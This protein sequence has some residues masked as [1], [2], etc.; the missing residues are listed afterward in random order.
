MK[1]EEAIEYITSLQAYGIVP[2]LDNIKEL[3][4]RLGNPQKDL[5]FIHITGTNGKGSVS[6]YI[7]TVLKTA[8]YK[9]GRYSS[10]TLFEY[11][12]RIKIGERNITKKSL[13]EYTERIKK[14]CDEIVKD[15]LPHPTPF[16]FETAMAFAYFKEMQCD[17]VVLETGMGG[18]LDAT[19]V[20][21][22]VLA[23]VFTPISMDHMKFLGN[24]LEEIAKNKA[25]IIKPNCEVVTI[26]QKEEVMKV[27]NSFAEE[28]KCAV[29]IADPLQAKKQKSN[30]KG[31]SFEYKSKDK[32]EISLLGL[33]QM[34][35]AI[36]AIETMQALK[37]KGIVVSEKQLR[38]GLLET[39]WPCRFQ[40]LS[41]NPIFIADGAHN[42]D[43]AKKL[44]DSIRFYFTNKKIVYI[45]GI[46]KDKEYEKIIS[47]TYSLAE[48][49][50]TITPPENPRALH[51][52][53]LANV[54]REYHPKVTALDS[55]E[56]AIELATLLAGKDGIIISFGSLSYFGKLK[57]CIENRTGSKKN[58]KS[59]K[60]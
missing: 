60:S 20:V 36:L 27:L 21:E 56:E 32:F 5:K 39:R 59:R 3:C 57:K 42:E 6:A 28:K 58:G 44:A 40:I 13:V 17:L 50:I 12:E 54:V 24:T 26:V 1:Y 47:E 22:N 10:P 11:S 23:A 33:Y 25:G 9:V 41:R 16:E 52:M 53:E 30:L 48:Q 35:N 45:M 15:G 49:I 55:L 46:L 34:Q 4:N 31:S 43:G 7:A 14:I 19:N 18:A 2:G 37:G 8:G 29:T 38:K 51:S